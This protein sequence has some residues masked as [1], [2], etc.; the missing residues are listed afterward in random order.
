MYVCVYAF[1]TCL[2]YEPFSSTFSSFFHI[3]TWR[4]RVTVNSPTQTNKIYTYIYVHIHTCMHEESVLLWDLSNTENQTIYIHICTHTYMQ[5]RTG[6]ISFFSLLSPVSSR[7]HDGSVLPWSLQYSKTAYIYIYIHTH[8]HKHTCMY[9]YKYRYDKL[10]FVTF[11]CFFT[12]A[13]RECVALVSPIQWHNW[14]VARNRAID[15]VYVR[16]ILL[17]MYVCMYV[18]IYASMY[19]C[20]C[21]WHNWRVAGNRAID[22]V[23]V[24]TSF[25][26]FIYVCMYAYMRLCMYVCVYDTTEGLQE[27]APSMTYMY[28]TSFCVCMY[29]CMYVCIYASMYV[30]MYVWH[31]WSVAGNCSVNDVYVRHVLLCMYVC[32]YVCIYVSVRLCMYV[33]MYVITEGLQE[34]APSITYM[35]GTSFCA[36]MY[37]CMYKTEKLQE[38]A[39]SMTYMYGTSLYVC[40]Y[41]CMCACMWSCMYVCS[42]VCMYVWNNCSIGTVPYCTKNACLDTH[43][44]MHTYIHTHIYQHQHCKIL[45][46]ECMIRHT[47]IHAHIHTHTHILQFF[48]F[49]IHTYVLHTYTYT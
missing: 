21:V 45:H 34:T 28:G 37:A 3:N 47:Y 15:D 23:Y 4:E 25:C 19:V 20:M 16:N 42:H 1:D 49:F 11:S 48:Y 22:D 27:T 31:N 2:Y 26:A 41:V 13:W 38:T 39:P 43:T 30:C 17:R 32:M 29:A 14:R 12:Y 6:M 40:M 44:Y 24:G 8:T 5:T 7:M 18:C 10:F 9:I 33:C 36:C 35:Y 46:Q